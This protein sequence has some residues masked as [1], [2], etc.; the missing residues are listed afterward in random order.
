MK[1]VKRFAAAPVKPQF[2]GRSP[3]IAPALVTISQF[4][5]SSMNADIF[6]DAALFSGIPHPDRVVV[7][8]RDTAG[9][10]VLIPLQ[11]SYNPARNEIAAVTAKFGEFV[12]CWSDDD[13]LASPPILVSPADRDSVNQRLPVPFAWNP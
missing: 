8:Q 12:F 7:F 5:I 4:G 13:T 11:T 1:S 2:S 3:S 9:Q 6:F 10:G